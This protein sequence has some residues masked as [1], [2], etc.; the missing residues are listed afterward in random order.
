MEQRYSDMTVEQLR[1]VVSKLT[2]QARKAEQMGMVNEYAVYQRKIQMAKSYMVNPAT[3]SKGD[4]YEIEGSPAVYFEIQYMN[5][6]F[7][8]GRRKD[9][10]GTWLEV[11]GAEEYEALPISMLGNKINPS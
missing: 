1:D 5:G 10:N 2:E 6:I 11:Q 3:F 7:A 8:W 9:E 4:V